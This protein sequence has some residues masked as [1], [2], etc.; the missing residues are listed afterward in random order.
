MRGYVQGLSVAVFD[1]AGAIAPFIYGTLADNQ[2]IEFCLWTGAV[3][4]LVAAAINTPL[5]FNPRLAGTATK[6]EKGREEETFRFSPE[7]IT[8]SP[9]STSEEAG[10]GSV[11]SSGDHVVYDC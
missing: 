5:V 7:E 11:S 4:S 2:G 8:E 6:D 9:E 1:G 10:D 3:V